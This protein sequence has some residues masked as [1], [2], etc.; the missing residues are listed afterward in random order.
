M[1]PKHAYIHLLQ[2]IGWDQET[3]GDAPMFNA[4][5]FDQSHLEFQIHNWDIFYSKLWKVAGLC[6][7]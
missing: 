5:F 2:N 7:T 3:D 4:G 6:Y 1:L